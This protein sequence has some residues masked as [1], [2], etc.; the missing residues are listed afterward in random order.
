L[1]INPLDDQTLLRQIALAKPEALSEMYDRYG[2]LVFSL[3]VRI[4]GDEAQAEEVTQ[5]V[6][7]QLWNKASVY[8]PEQGKVITWL[9]SFAR[10]RSIDMLRRRSVRPE[11]HRTDLE[12]G[13]S[14]SL[15]NEPDYE[16]NVD[17]KAEKL[18]LRQAITH[19]PEEQQKVLALAYYYGL[20]H[21]E[22]SDAIHEPLGTV[23]TRLR[24]AM[25]KLRQL[26]FDEPI[27]NRKL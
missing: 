8:R 19:L 5:D 6:F 2:R 4:L 22:I 20:S 24:L 27:S 23:K 16:E 9:T 17:L 12:D 3:A 14:P 18:R 13:I 1:R 7:I 26:L 21:Q 25:Q 11:G 15:K 10:Y